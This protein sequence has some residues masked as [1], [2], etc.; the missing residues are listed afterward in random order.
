MT[1]LLVSAVGGILRDNLAN[2]PE[3]PQLNVTQLAAYKIRWLADTP[4]YQDAFEIVAEKARRH[5]WGQ[6][7]DLSL[8]PWS[9]LLAVEGTRR[10]IPNLFVF[11]CLA[12]LVSLSFAQNLFYVALLLTPAP[13]PNVQQHPTRWIRIRE[14]VF[15]PKPPNWCLS[16]K[17]FLLSSLVSYGSIF[18][19]P[20]AAE[21]PSFN[22]IIGISRACTFI[23]LL[24]QKTAPASWG[25]VHPDPHKAHAA[26]TDLFRLM[27][28]MSATLHAVATVTGL[29]YNLPYSHYHRHSRFLPWDMEKRTKWERTTTAVGR[30]LGSTLDHPAVAAVGYDVLLSGTGA[31]LWAAVRSLGASDILT[32]VVPLYDDGREDATPEKPS[33]E[34]SQPSLST[35][36]TTTGRS[37]RRSGRNR[38]ASNSVNSTTTSHDGEEEHAAPPKARRRGRPRKVRQDPE[39]ESGDKT[40]VPSSP[41][42]ASAEGDALPS[43]EVDLEAA[44]LAWGLMAV[45]GLGLGSAGVFGGEC[46][47]R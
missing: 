16:P 26:F 25:S 35:S 34:P 24:L 32:S 36:T 15:S 20:Y 45:G 4:I 41:E 14:S 46:L 8:V 31:G 2:A 22:R 19:L 9:A 42:K 7:I 11:L 17:F 40:Y 27:S 3:D 23:P 37:V 33:D 38:A 13:L 1:L 10:R 5:W 28:F 29:R 30:V 6:Q 39:E 12:H 43:Q 18:L 47:A 21:T 44:A